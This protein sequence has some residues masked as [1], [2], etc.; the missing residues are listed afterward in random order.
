MTYDELENK[1]KDYRKKIIICALIT[2]GLA[3]L[4]IFLTKRIAFVM[5]AVIIGVILK[6]IIATKAENEYS[7]AYKDYFV[8]SGL[9]NIFTDIR[10]TPDKGIA[11]STIAN[12][13]MMYM[14]DRYNSNDLISAKY[15]GINFTQADVHIEEE[16][17][18][19]DSEGHTRTY[20]VTI[21]RGRWMMFD[22][23]KNFKS[24]VQVAEKGFGNNH[25]DK[26]GLFS[27]KNEGEY[28]KKVEMESTS[29]NNKFK[30]YAQSEHEA[31][32]LLTPALMEKIE[33]LA[34]NNGGKILLC[35]INNR[36]HIGLYDGKDSFEAPNCFK[37]INEENEINKTNKDILTISQFVDELSL[38]NDLFRKEV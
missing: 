11:E 16:R 37:K 28:Y 23:N 27:K 31:F 3:A 30:V 8:K 35:F 7:K 18:S 26:K 38:D 6:L 2:I 24:N 9:K 10:Y 20:Y 12:T 4:I 25:V 32:Y 29:F 36:L 17:Q 1:R 19:T 22:F 5:I 14:G 21:F 33:R 15:K 34:A 13:R